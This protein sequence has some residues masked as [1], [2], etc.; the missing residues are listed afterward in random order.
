MF[1][2]HLRFLYWHALRYAL[3]SRHGWNRYINELFGVKGKTDD[4]GYV[5]EFETVYNSCWTYRD[6]IYNDGVGGAYDPAAV[7][8]HQY[9]HD[10]FADDREPGTVEFCDIDGNALAIASFSMAQRDLEDRFD[11]PTSR[12]DYHDNW[13]GFNPEVLSF[14]CVSPRMHASISAT[15]QL[16][17]FRI[18]RPFMESEVVAETDVVLMGS[19]GLPG[20]GCD[21][22]LPVIDIEQGKIIKITKFQIRLG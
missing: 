5:D 9:Q 3:Y 12:T 10:D 21:L 1:S 16:S 18:V 11:M 14:N 17:F 2:E 13:R 22:E 7:I 8:G 20:S 19:I 4:L 15:G 6:A